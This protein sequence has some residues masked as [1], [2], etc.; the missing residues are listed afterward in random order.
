[1]IMHHIEHMSIDSKVMQTQGQQQHTRK[2]SM[3]Y[4]LK[5]KTNIFYTNCASNYLSNIFEM[6]I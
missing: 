5:V 1:M 6:R 2:I 3:Q 4:N